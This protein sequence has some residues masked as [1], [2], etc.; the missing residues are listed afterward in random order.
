MKAPD[1]TRRRFVS[2]FLFALAAVFLSPTSLWHAR[3][4]FWRVPHSDEQPL[5][6]AARCASLALNP[7]PPPHFH[8]RTHSDRFDP[9]TPA[10]LIRNAQIWTGMHNGTEVIH[11]DILLENGLITAVGRVEESLI[12]GH[13]HLKV[14]DAHSAWVTPGIIDMHSHMGDDSLPELN[15]AVDYY[16]PK[17]VVAPW[18]RTLDGLN[19]HD[20][21]YE[22]SIAGG[23]TTAIILPGSAG[24]IGGQAF[25]IKLR[26]TKERNPTSMLL[27]PPVNINTSFPDNHITPRWRHLKQACGENPVDQ[28]GM[29]RMDVAW[30]FREAY[31]KAR[32]L[33][34]SQD[35]FCSKLSH[36]ETEPG[37]FPEDLQWEMLV[38]VLRGKVKVHTHCYEAVDLDQLIRLSEEFQFPIASVH[39]ASEAYLVPQLLEKGFGQ[40][41]F[42]PSSSSLTVPWLVGPKPAVALFAT[43]TR[44]KREAY[45]G[46]E[47]APRILAQHGFDVVMKSDHPVMNS[48]YLLFEAQQAYHF[49]LPQN[50]AI[51]SVT[52]TPAHVLGLAHRIGYISRGWDADLV[53]WDSHPLAIG[54]S[55]I[56]VFI[57]GISQ[58][59]DV[60][61]ATKPSSHQKVPSVPNYDNEAA[62]AVDYH[63]L[64]PLEPRKK[65]SGQV[66]FSN[67]SA[68]LLSREVSN[69][70][71]IETDHPRIVVLVDSGHVQCVGTEDSC[72]V[73]GND[74]ETI[75]LKGGMVSPGLISFGAPL[76]TTQILAEKSTNDG[77]VLNPF[78]KKVPSILGD[79]RA[80]VRAVDG[81]QFGSRDA[82][83]AYRS[84]VTNAITAPSH[85]GLIGGLGV[86]FSLGATHPLR[87]GAIIRDVAG[88]HV[89]VSHSVRGPSI[90]TQIATLRH[91]LQPDAG[92]NDDYFAEVTKGYIP[93]VVEAHSADII[94]AL[95]RLK[96]EVE[97]RIGGTIKMT[98]TGASEAHLLAAELSRANVGIILN[99]ARPFPLTWEDQRILPGPPL[100]EDTAVSKL[101]AHNVTV[102]IGVMESWDARN[103]RFDMI[104]AALEA[105]GKITHNQ[106]IALVSSNIEKLLTGSVSPAGNVDLIVLEGGGLFDPQSK[107]VA[108]ISPLQ[109]SVDIL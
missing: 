99:P 100:S 64:P 30:A 106:A 68:C 40:L 17:A 39:H 44:Y 85:E 46:S 49:G 55:P 87:P 65:I 80:I 7:G 101:L 107:V 26:K 6:A 54:A 75:D 27:E 72:P 22:L 16:S 76:G 51:A 4:P 43:Q 20:L 24:A 59:S 9:D 81:L 52:T 93:L 82:L 83:I 41:F 1:K 67:V 23:V 45:R 33:K 28:F 79:G 34:A 32:R 105:G 10:T 95:I 35:E 25:P 12:Q 36:G 71:L 37:Q 86:H 57:D 74:F 69:P 92:V 18:A 2:L 89:S 50:L 15:G 29:T 77:E 78:A 104:W 21:S 19:T 8:H 88:L 103:T 11:G 90:S 96:A 62:A 98:I 108:V 48:R 94:A 66:L 102:G 53:V 58:L 97:T 70:P 42:Y 13:K 61:M 5:K 14:I 38:D 109:H 60:H 3:S 31:D 73:S 63:G 84:G 47:Y 56:Y 91:L